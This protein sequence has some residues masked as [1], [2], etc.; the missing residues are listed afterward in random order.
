MVPKVVG[1]VLY[2]L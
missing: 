2:L 1:S